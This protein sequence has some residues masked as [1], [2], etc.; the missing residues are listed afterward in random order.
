MTS[1]AGRYQW[2]FV[3]IITSEPGLY[4]IGSASN[5][6]NACTVATAIENH[7]KPFWLGKDPDRIGDLWQNT[8]TRSYWRNGSDIEQRAERRDVALS[9]H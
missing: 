1:P 8:S 6:N 4:G 3:K 2:I 7:L 5:V 9:G